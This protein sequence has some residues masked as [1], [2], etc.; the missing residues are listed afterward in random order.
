MEAYHLSLFAGI[1]ACF[2]ATF[3]LAGAAAI[4]LDVWLFKT[5]RTTISRFTL[6]TFL[7]RPLG[8][9]LILLTLSH[10]VVFSIGALFGHLILYQCP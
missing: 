8:V 5:G 9:A 7:R 2:F 3:L 1:V 4:V 6:N 10:G